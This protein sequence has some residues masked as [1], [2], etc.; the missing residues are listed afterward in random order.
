[1]CACACACVCM[2]ACVYGRV[3]YIVCSSICFLTAFALNKYFLRLISSLM[4]SE[5][6]N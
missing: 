2:G 1:M 6:N 5:V 4:F 3:Y